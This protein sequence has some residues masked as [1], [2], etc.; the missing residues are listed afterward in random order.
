VQKS[1]RE[2]KWKERP[3]EEKFGG[4]YDKRDKEYI[5]KKK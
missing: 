3:R 1:C 4:K 2:V 5:E